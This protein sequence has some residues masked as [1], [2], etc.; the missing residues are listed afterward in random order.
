MIFPPSCTVKEGMISFG[1]NER[2]SK[3]V[4]RLGDR[5]K[6]GWPIAFQN[7]NDIMHVE[8]TSSTTVQKMFRV[9]D[10]VVQATTI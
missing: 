6:T 8:A 7:A 9:K 3:V 2:P 10:F 4:R 1:L 5:D